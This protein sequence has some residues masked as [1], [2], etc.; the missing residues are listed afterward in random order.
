MLDGIVSD[1]KANVASKSHQASVA[2]GFI[3]RDG[4]KIL[5][6]F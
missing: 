3:E 2:D 4:V 5:P 6:K 1:R